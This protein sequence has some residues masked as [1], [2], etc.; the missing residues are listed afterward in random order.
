MKLYQLALYKS[1]KDFFCYPQA[2]SE[3]KLR[4]LREEKMKAQWKFEVFVG[5]ILA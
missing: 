3:K 2:S 1:F 4:Y 5:F